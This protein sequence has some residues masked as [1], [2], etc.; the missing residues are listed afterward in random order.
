MSQPVEVQQAG[1]PVWVDR[2]NKAFHGNMKYLD[3][4]KYSVKNMCTFSKEKKVG[5]KK[6]LKSLKYLADNKVGALDFA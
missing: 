4:A 5:T 1:E 2:S 3:S 6:L